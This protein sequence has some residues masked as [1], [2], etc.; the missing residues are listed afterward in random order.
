M[1]IIKRH[2]G[3]FSAI[4]DIQTPGFAQ[5]YSC[6]VSSPAC[7]R[8][9]YLTAFAISSY[10]RKYENVFEIGISRR[11]D[12]HAV[13]FGPRSNAAGAGSHRPIGHVL[14]VGTDR[15]PAQT[16][17]PSPPPRCHNQ[18]RGIALTEQSLGGRISPR[19]ASFH[20]F[21]S[22]HFDLSAPASPQFRHVPAHRLRRVALA[23]QVCGAQH[24]RQV[25]SRASAPAQ[26]IRGKNNLE[27]PS[28]ARPQNSP[29]VSV[30]R[31]GGSDSR[32]DGHAPPRPPRL[33][34][35]LRR[36]QNR[37]AP[38]CSH[39]IRVDQPPLV[40]LS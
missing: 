2:F 28:Y 16:S 7:T 24:A 31:V 8:I 20:R 11:H 17:S 3:T 22:S 1:T 15:K 34:D 36:L 9:R 26:D 13:A 21:R 14:R 37:H 40:A 25:T 4:G 23:T 38:R 30:H 10:R 6:S 19:D 32:D 29:G 33:R 12:R 39:S 27:E 5:Y 18:G 35:D